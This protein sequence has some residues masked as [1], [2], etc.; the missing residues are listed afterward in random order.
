MVQLLI[1]ESSVGHEFPGREESAYGQLHGKPGA[2]DGQKDQWADSQGWP[3]HWQIGRDSHCEFIWRNSVCR[4]SLCEFICRNAVCRMSL[5]KFICRN[6]VCMVSLCKYI[7]R[8]TVCMV[9]LWFLFSSGAR[10]KAEIG[11]NTPV[12]SLMWYVISSLAIIFAMCQSQKV[13]PVGHA[14][15]LHL[16][17]SLSQGAT[18]LGRI[19]LYVWTKSKH[20]CRAFL[21]VL[22]CASHFQRAKSVRPIQ[23]KYAWSLWCSVFSLKILICEFLSNWSM[24][25]CWKFWSA[26][27]W[28]AG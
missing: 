9:S 14:W 25:I 24:L 15:G 4:M 18:H 20:S 12:L 8:N 3:K 13:T 17:S 21:Q 22:I 19:P 2:A 5:C 11:G 7:C 23:W 1:A 6:A 16:S 10:Y 28:Q 27:F 26:N